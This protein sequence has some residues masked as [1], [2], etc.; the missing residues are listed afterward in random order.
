KWCAL[1]PWH[2]AC[3]GSYWGLVVL[4]SMLP[5]LLWRLLDEE[6]SSTTC[7]VTGNIGRRLLV[8]LSRHGFRP[9][10]ERLQSRA[11]HQ[12]HRQPA[13]RACDKIAVGDQAFSG[14]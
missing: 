12:R 10:D 9:R 8:R 6:R 4:C 11:P 3:M 13:V 1:P 7:L 14:S 5:F 2:S